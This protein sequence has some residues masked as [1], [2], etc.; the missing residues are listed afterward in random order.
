MAIRLF[1]DI[2][3]IAYFIAIITLNKNKVICTHIA[4]TMAYLRHFGF[5]HWLAFLYATP[6]LESD[7]N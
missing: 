4:I 1:R 3:A 2:I 7:R 5:L 6:H